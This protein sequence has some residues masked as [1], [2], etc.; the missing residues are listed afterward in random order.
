MSVRVSA[1]VGTQVSGKGLT[2]F[3]LLTVPPPALEHATLHQPISPT[4]NKDAAE[5]AL[6]KHC[7]H[8]VLPAEHGSAP[9]TGEKATALLWGGRRSERLDE[10]WR[11]QLRAH[12]NTSAST[13]P[14]A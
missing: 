14:S 6:A 3:A 9:N 1:V 7:A 10:G 12:P 4:D 13:G 8:D 2:A 5:Q 11:R